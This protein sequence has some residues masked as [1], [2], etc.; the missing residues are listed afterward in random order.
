MH[1]GDGEFRMEERGFQRS[2][3]EARRKQES[4]CGEVGVGAAVTEN[5]SGL[6]LNDHPQSSL[7]NVK[8]NVKHNRCSAI[9]VTSNKT[10]QLFKNGIFIQLRACCSHLNIHICFVLLLIR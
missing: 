1:E 6:N 4:A 3:K 10:R 5:R 2:R 8:Q 7:N 9:F